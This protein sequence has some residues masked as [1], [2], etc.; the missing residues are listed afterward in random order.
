MSLLHTGNPFTSTKHPMTLHIPE[1]LAE[2]LGPLFDVLPYDEAMTELVPDRPMVG[3]AHDAVGAMIDHPALAEFPSLR[4]GL[5]LYVD[6]LDASHAISQGITTPTGSFWHA[7]MHRREGDFSNSQYWYRKAGN[8]PAMRRID[9]TGG[10]AGSGTDV[11]HYDPYA[12]VDRVEHA[13]SSTAPGLNA[14]LDQEHPELVS[15]QRKEWRAL[16]EFCAEQG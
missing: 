16:F 8:H 15:L 11:A 3:P 2:V 5:W 1:P 14:G 12:F 6:D 4:A 9:L 7:V 10:G 13:M